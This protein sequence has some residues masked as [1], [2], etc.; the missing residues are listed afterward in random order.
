MRQISRLLRYVLLSLLATLAM[1]AQA[2]N[3]SFGLSLNNDKLTLTHQGNATAFYP[4][5]YRLQANGHWQ[6]LAVA[7][8]QGEANQLAPTASLDFI[9]G[10]TR[11]LNTLP[12]LEALRPIMVRFF[13]QAGSGFGQMSFFNQPLLANEPLEGGYKHGLMTIAPPKSSSN[14]PISATWVLWP[15]EDGISPLRYPVRFEHH[16]PDARRIEWRPGMDKVELNLGAGLPT[17]FL[18]HETPQGLTFQTMNDGGI[19]GREQRTAWLDLTPRFFVAA[20]F[21]AGLAVVVL[22]YSLLAGGK[23]KKAA[24]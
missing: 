8:G 12:P 4:A 21:L 3:I 10:D 7:P 17:A 23:D 22:A 5:V 11:P 18:L 2:G 20:K 1:S 24:A 14:P 16:Q 6:R 19:Q 9:W 13:D 15:Q